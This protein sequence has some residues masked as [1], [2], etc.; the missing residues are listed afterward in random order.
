MVYLI[1]YIAYY[2]HGRMLLHSK[3]KRYMEI[4][5]NRYFVNNCYPSIGLYLPILAHILH[6]ILL[7]QRSCKLQGALYH[8]IYTITYTSW[9]LGLK[10][11]RPLMLCRFDS[12]PG[13]H[14][15]RLIY[16][17]L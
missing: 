11:P 5:M 8:T 9:Y 13:Y 16:S 6:N 2:L 7:T 14:S 3:C 10:I 4:E 15:N 17:H 12:G 1:R